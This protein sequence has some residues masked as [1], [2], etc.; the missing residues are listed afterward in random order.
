MQIQT[1]LKNFGLNDKEIAVYLT[2]VELGPSP[3]RAVSAKAKV[4]RGT[5]YDILKEL[6]KQ[7]LVSFYDAKSHQYFAAEPPEKL[8]S[9]LEDKQEHLEELK[10]QVKESLPELKT[11]FE[12][13]GGKPVMKMYEGATGI[14]MILEDLLE[15]VSKLKNRS[16]YLYSSSTAEDR[17]SIYEAMPDFSKKRIAKKINVKIISLGAGGQL[18]GLDERKWMPVGGQQPKST[19]EIIYAGKVAHISLDNAENPVGVVIQNQ[20]IYETQ[21]MIFEFTWKKL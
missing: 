12:K 6:I 17:K 1:I 5:S 3:V 20:E 18:A 10:I 11:L 16:Y 21:K 8:L 14:K 7:G 4:N 15:E 2:L 19:H 9:A 13:Q